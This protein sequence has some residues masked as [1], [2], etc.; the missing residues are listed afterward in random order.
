MHQTPAHSL[1]H[2]YLRTHTHFLAYAQASTHSLSLLVSSLEFSRNNNDLWRQDFKNKSKIFSSDVI[3]DA[4][5]KI[6]ARIWA[7]P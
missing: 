2:T 5:L 4:L 6:R 3:P 1:L 7:R